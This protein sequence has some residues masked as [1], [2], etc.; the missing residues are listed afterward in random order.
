MKKYNPLIKIHLEQNKKSDVDIGKVWG[1]PKNKMWEVRKYFNLPTR[2][3]VLK[4]VREQAY[5]HN[6][7]VKAERK[8]IW[9]EQDMK[10]IKLWNDG[11]SVLSIGNALRLGTYYVYQKL[12][13]L[14]HKG[15]Q[16]VY[17]RSAWKHLR[18]LPA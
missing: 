10:L 3:E 16:V 5:I 11:E 8:N 6:Q 14:K 17:R 13:R 2:N 7:K 12:I 1:I 18:I 4:A 15:F 9:H